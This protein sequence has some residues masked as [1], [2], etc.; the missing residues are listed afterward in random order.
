MSF[1]KDELKREMQEAGFGHLWE[2]VER[3]GREG[4]A[5]RVG[6]P[7]SFRLDK[8]TVGLQVFYEYSTGTL[9]KSDIHRIKGLFGKKTIILTDEAI[10]RRMNPFPDGP[11]VSYASKSRFGGLPDL[12]DGFEWPCSESHYYE[13]LCQ[14]K[15]DELPDCEARSLLP[16]SGMLSFFVGA[17]RESEGDPPVRCFYFSDIDTLKMARTHPRN[18]GWQRESHMNERECDPETN[19]PSAI[20]LSFKPQFY[21]PFDEMWETCKT[22]PGNALWQL[23]SDLDS[24]E[25]E[26]FEKLIHGVYGQS[27]P[28]LAWQEHWLLGVHQSIQGP[29]C[30]ESYNTER[31]RASPDTGRILL[32][33]MGP[34]GPYGWGDAGN[35]YF[36]IR[37]TDLAACNFDDVQ[38]QWDCY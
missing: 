1:P 19:A 13:F 31:L 22:S 25:D 8:E 11:E 9:P 2:F 27:E 34:W 7:E 32:M 28:E 12:P 17:D 20:P 5:I 21:F 30:I 14:I 4:I 33:Q 3:D 24:S 16:R 38:V 6:N 23:I 15:L 36:T 29:D 35:L 18:A 10:E 37:P 26:R